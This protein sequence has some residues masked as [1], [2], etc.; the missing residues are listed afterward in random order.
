[1]K[2]IIKNKGKYLEKLINISIEHYN[3]KGIAL[4]FKRKIE[5]S[6]LNVKNINSLTNEIGCDYYGIYRGKYILLEAKEFSNNYFYLK[7]I[8]INQWK[9]MKMTNK[10]GG[11]CYFI[12]Y[13]KLH[14]RCFII[15]L[16]EMMKQK[17]KINIKFLKEKK[18]EIF[19]K[20][21]LYL[22]FL[23]II[24]LHLIN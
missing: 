17:S 6:F 8:R 2:Q 22:D 16:N 20:N 3:E 1:M 24:N 9:E 4:F 21:Y 13:S 7:N 5:K 11:L 12:L 19:I 14:E 10:L 23:N 15:S 18:Y